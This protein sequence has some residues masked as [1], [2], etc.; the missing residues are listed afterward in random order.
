[1][2]PQGSSVSR[3]ALL[4][5]P[6][7]AHISGSADGTLATASIPDASPRPES[8]AQVNRSRTDPPALRSAP[9]R[10]RPVLR[11]RRRNPGVTDC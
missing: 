7:T 10:F 11:T 3:R 5:A 9:S 4:Q 2:G 1:M 6:V 8:T